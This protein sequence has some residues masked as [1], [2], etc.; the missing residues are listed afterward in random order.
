MF[1]KER[2]NEIKNLVFDTIGY[3]TATEFEVT[4]SDGVFAEKKD[5]K[6]TVDFNLN[7][8]EWEAEVQNAYERNKGKYQRFYLGQLDRW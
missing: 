2:A 3:K 6:I 8:D 1:T 7:A 5:G 4:E